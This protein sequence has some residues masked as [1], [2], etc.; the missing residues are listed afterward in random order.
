MNVAG[1]NLI[2][3]ACLTVVCGLLFIVDI[4]IS[5]DTQATLRLLRRGDKID[6]RMSEMRGTQ[7]MTDFDDP[8]NV[9]RPNLWLVADQGGVI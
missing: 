6:C 5:R 8:A 3:T 2:C 9:V 1:L 7:P 4:S